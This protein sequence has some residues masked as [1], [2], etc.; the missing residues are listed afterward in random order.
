MKSPAIMYVYAVF[1]AI[2]GFIA[3]VMSEF[4]QI[5]ALIPVAMGLIMAAMG[6]LASMIDRNKAAGMIGVHIG[7]VLPVLYA[8]MF[9]MLGYRRASAEDPAMYLVTIFGVMFVGSIIAFVAILKT[10]PKPEARG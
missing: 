2:C 9:G 5:T 8:L 6:W 1:L 7:L 4:E 10:R 3:Y